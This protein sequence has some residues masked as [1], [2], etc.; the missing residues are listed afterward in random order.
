MW[1]G[2]GVGCVGGICRCRYV[3]VWMCLGCC[4]GA[5]AWEREDNMREGGREGGREGSRG[6][7]WV[8]RETRLWEWVIF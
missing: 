1:F 4:M 6:K 3:W 5:W 7:G 2:V 8:E